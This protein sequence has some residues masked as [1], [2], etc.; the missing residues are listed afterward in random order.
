MKVKDLRELTKD[1]L[2]HKHDE[3]WSDLFGMRIKHALG[4]LENPLLLRGARRDIARVRTL[5][6]QQGVAEVSRRRRQTPTA[7]SAG[8][9]AAGGTSA[10]S[11]GAART[12]EA[13]GAAKQD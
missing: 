8:G 10:R 4:Q 11:K 12:A 9:K 3:L 7:K 2:V 13:A 6:R 1:E 5:L